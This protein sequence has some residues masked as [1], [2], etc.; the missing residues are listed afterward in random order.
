MIK[1]KEDQIKALTASTERNTI[2]KIEGFTQNMRSIDSQNLSTGD[3]F[4]IPTNPEVYSMDFNGNSAEFIVVEVQGNFC[5]RFFPSTFYKNGMEVDKEGLFTGNRLYSTGKVCED[6]RN[7]ETVK[8]AMGKLAG[9]KVKVTNIN[10][11]RVASRFDE[12]GYTNT[13]FPVI[14]Y[15]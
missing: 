10:Y 8:E 6:A 5:K 15:A 2:K 1:S 13:G 9:K 11:A 4:T 7:C 12:R 3:E 14:E